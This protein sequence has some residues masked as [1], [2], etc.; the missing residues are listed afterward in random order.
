MSDWFFRP[1]AA[2]S[3]FLL[4]RLGRPAV[5]GLEN[6]PDAGGFI[7]VAN[8]VSLADPPIIG[9]AAGYRT[10]RIIHFMAKEEMRRW[11]ILGWLAERSG[12][13]FVRRGEGDR[14]SQREALAML[15]RG[16]PIALFPEGTRSRDAVLAEGK[17]GAALLAIRSGAPLLPVA[18]SGSERIFPGMSRMPHRTNVTVRIGRPFELPHQ[19]NGRLDR[20]MLSAGTERIMREIAALLPARQR[21]RHG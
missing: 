11:P 5:I 14:A 7:L 6:V 21:G 3:A 2:A 1:G 9:W 17:A 8:H 12:V 18:I 15:A 20:A 19:P 16:E 10:H 13:F 4:R